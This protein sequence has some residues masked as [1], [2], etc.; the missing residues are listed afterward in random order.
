M[1][2]NNNTD[3]KFIVMQ[4]RIPGDSFSTAYDTA[5]D[6]NAAAET[7]WFYL[8]PNERKHTHVY[9]IVVRRE[10]LDE[11]AIDEDTGD[12]DWCMWVSADT[13]PGAFDSEHIE[14]EEE[15]E[16]YYYDDDD[17]EDEEEDAA[18]IAAF[19][20]ARPASS[21]K[22]SAASSTEP[23]LTTPPI[24][25]TLLEN[26]P[27]RWNSDIYFNKTETLV[28]LPWYEKICSENR[29]MND[30]DSLW[31]IEDVYRGSDGKFY[32]CCTCYSDGHFG[33]IGMYA[34][35]GLREE[36]NDH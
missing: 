20:P 32:T 5:E 24:E 19:A 33:E 6:A 13:F 4:D 25:F 36:K 23:A 9:A 27:N 26:D 34:E 30:I 10:D 29:L 8:T 1:T 21:S 31:D 14:A 18:I 7:V 3:R 22:C 12:I 15:E 35:L 28:I 16:D 17:E 11:D 2:N